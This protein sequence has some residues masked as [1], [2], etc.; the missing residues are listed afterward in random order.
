MNSTNGEW[1]Y[2]NVDPDVE[3]CISSEKSLICSRGSEMIA[4]DIFSSISERQYFTKRILRLGTIESLNK[5]LIIFAS[6][7]NPS[8]SEA[9]YEDPT[10]Q[11]LSK[12]NS[13]FRIYMFILK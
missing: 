6:L 11:I 1:S 2:V 10:S 3:D 4:S 8:R 9:T 12:I 13:I 5:Y 7:D